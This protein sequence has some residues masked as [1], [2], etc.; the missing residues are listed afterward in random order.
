MTHRQGGCL[1]GAVRYV[2]KAEPRP[3][4]ICHCTHCRK[5]SGSLFSFN[6]VVR[7]SDYEQQGETKVFVDTGD[8]GQ[9]VHRH[10]CG[11]CG[12]PVFVKIAAAPRHVVIKAGSLDD[13]GGL[14]AN[15][16]IYCDH[17]TDWIAPVAG[18]TRFAQNQ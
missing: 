18:A 3:G 4:T 17:A 8:S 10:F 7:D 14:Q 13:I 1:C 11:R 9:P 12:S 2:I 16:E 15:T 6:L 5:Q